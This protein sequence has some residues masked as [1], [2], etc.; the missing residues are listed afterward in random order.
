[1]PEGLIPDE[2]LAAWLKRVVDPAGA[3]P[4]SWRLILWVND[5]DPD[6]A[7]VLASLTQ[8]SFGG[9][10]FLTLMP[11]AWTAP[12]V[13][14]GC[15]TT[16]YTTDAYTWYVTNAMGQT[17]YGWALTDPGAGE[18]R[19]IQRFDDADIAPLETG[20]RLLLLP[21]LTMTSAACGGSMTRRRSRRR[22]LK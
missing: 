18:L 10:N 5:L 9:Y 13:V 19:F 17:V 15:A 3:S 2:G 20:G 7:T 8:A 11:G 4:A 16:T 22:T 21:T 12:A 6:N 1:M 14:S